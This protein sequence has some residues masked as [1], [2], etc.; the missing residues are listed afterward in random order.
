MRPHRFAL[1]D[2]A[3]T[4]VP[5]G[6]L[7]LGNFE[8][9][10]AGPP[11]KAARETIASWG[12]R[13]SPIVLDQNALV[14]EGA[15]GR[16]LFDAG[17][18]TGTKASTMFGT[19]AGQL[20][21]SLAAAGIAPDSIDAVVLT[22]AHCDHAWGLADAEG[23]PAFPNARVVASRRTL[24]EWTAL[25]ASNGAGLP[26]GYAENA[27]RVL[28]A[29]RDRIETFSDGDEVAPGVTLVAT[30]G[31]TLGHASYRLRS[32]GAELLFAGDLAHDPLQLAHPGLSY[33]FDADR[34]RGVESRLAQ[35]AALATAGTPVLAYH[36]PHPGLGRIVRA[37]DA[38]AWRP[39][40]ALPG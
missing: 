12:R 33:L 5:D 2:L 20:G 17:M 8:G 18:G 21:R 22:H 13:P 11:M 3:L 31:H 36:F 35:F 6:P 14:V 25:A 38:F 4:V 7:A 34:A 23:R 9:N 40:D 19:E 27:R 16:L 32:G 1:G 29:V 15:G 39:L 24:D 30:P 28:E 10:F 37:G 26:P